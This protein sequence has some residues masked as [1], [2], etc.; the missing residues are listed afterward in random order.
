MK[1]FLLYFF[2]FSSL[3]LVAEDRYSLRAAY[4]AATTSDLSEIFSGDIQKPEYDYRVFALDGGYLL[5]KNLLDIPLDF[6]LNGGVAYYDEDSV[7]DNVLEATLYIKFI[8]NIDIW[9]NKLRVG[10]GEGLSY[11]NRY[12]QVEYD[13]AIADHDGHSKVL[14]YLDISLDLDIGRL[15]NYG[16]LYDTYMGLL[17]KHRSGIFGLIGDVKEGGANY[18]A[19]YV[20]KVF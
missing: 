7:Q 18:Y 20:E 2:F 12:L 8:Y 1:L 17:I 14:N 3:S 16:P 5:K 10:L 4:G 15:V 13:E 11:T 19:V 6:Y 9:N